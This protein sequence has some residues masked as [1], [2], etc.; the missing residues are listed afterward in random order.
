[1][2]IYRV[3][4]PRKD[5]STRISYQAD[6]GEDP[7][8]GKRRRK[9]FEKRGDAVE[10]LR[11]K[12][13]AKEQGKAGITIAD[14]GEL[15]ARD[16]EAVGRERSTWSK[17]EEHFRNHVNAILLSA[18][19]LKDTTLGA[20]DVGKLSARHL[21]QF[22]ADLSKT[23]SHAMAKRVWS[24]LS[25]ALDH[26]VSIEARNDNP[27]WSVK[28]D[29]KPREAADPENNAK[30]PPREHIRAIHD[31]LRCR[32]LEE[33]T[34]GQ[35][36]LLTMLACGARPS[37][38][39]ALALPQLVLEGAAPKL[40]V[41][42]RAD[43]WGEIGA[44]KS[45]AGW[46]EIPL[47]L[48][49]VAMLKRWLAARPKPKK[50]ETWSRDLV[51]PTSTGHVQNAANIHNRVWVP[52]MKALGLARDTGRRDKEGEPILETIYPVYSL[53]HAYASIQIDI[54]I[55]PKT[56]QHRMGHSSIKQTLD[57]YGHLFDR[58]P[59][60]DAADMAAIEAWL[61]EKA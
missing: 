16:R 41:A 37:E 53:R 54:G 7:V 59:E 61:A 56:L 46:R 19:D 8:T 21:V 24:T 43:Q 35:A 2:A 60:K 58:R 52:L 25:A 1:M 31:A 57:T 36:F 42:A 27:C 23:R 48:T 14:I 9:K 18:G 44:P 12:T 10:W 15:F 49:A 22:R 6:A 17:Y 30:I 5:G 29:R 50:G 26:A 13:E 3:K 32:P 55:D 45:A 4:R 20:L 40:T 11:G 47:P 39:R 33:P 38:L 34:M 51:F 28:I